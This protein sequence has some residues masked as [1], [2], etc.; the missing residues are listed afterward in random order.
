MEKSA[1]RQ[2]LTPLLA[3][4]SVAIVGASEKGRYASSIIQNL[5]RSGFAREAVFPV[6]PNYPEIFG[7]RCYPSVKQIPGPVDLALAIVPYSAIPAVA[8]ECGEKGVRALSVISSGFA[9]RGEQ[10]RR[11]QEELAATARTF[12]M[13]LLGPNTLGHVFPRARALFWSSSVPERLGHGGVAAIFH[14]SGMLNLFF[15]TASQ[16]GLGFSLGLAPGNEAGLNLSDYLSWAVEDPETRVIALVIESIREPRRFCEAL[17]RARQLRKPIVALRLGRSARAKRSIISHTGSLA[18]TGEAWDALFEQKGVARVNN[19]D[20][21]VESAVFLAAAD[22]N[23]LDKN[24]LGLV[25]ISGGD[26]SLLSDICDRVGIV[27]PDLA[28]E[29]REIIA[30]ELKKDSFLGNP[31]DV[32]DLLQSNTDGFYRS[33]E[34]FSGFQPFGAIGCRLNIPDKPSARLRDSYHRIAQIVHGAGKQ[35]VFFSRASEPIHQEWFELFSAL[36]VPFLLEYEKGLRT[37]HRTIGLAAKWSRTDEEKNAQRGAKA[38][39]REPAKALVSPGDGG[40]LAAKETL[41]LLSAYGIPFARTEIA[42]SAGAVMELADSIGY[43]VVLKI[44]SIDIPHRSDIGAV[45]AGLASRAEV[46]L[47]YEQIMECCRKAK[48]AARIEGVAVQPMVEG[49]AEVILG[50]SRDAQLG[51]V[52]LLGIGGIFVEVI[53]DVVLRIP[54]LDLQDCREMIAALRGKALLMG[55]RGRPAGDL[56]ALCQATLALSRLALELEGEIAE[57]DLNPVIVRREG[58]GVVAVDGLVVLRAA[59]RAG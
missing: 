57:V 37:I 16:R 25:T 4:R 2:D 38:P 8:Q 20:E 29:S 32:E 43:P 27:L 53:K 15:I 39:L 42:S 22:L 44:S 55:S 3:P 36:K 14:S 48:P 23:R 10:G 41:A 31:L 11:R 59:V 35:V 54:P 7:L 47:A 33:L 28:G 40:P 18:S 51:P 46:G 17:D 9:E 50:I 49:V 26:C 5:A 45:K 56:E 13:A 21:L 58:Q 52:I 34:A 1:D 12:G 19:L 24:S 6:N 30:R